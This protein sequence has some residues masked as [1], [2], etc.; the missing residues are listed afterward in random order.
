MNTKLIVRLKRKRKLREKIKSLGLYRLSVNRTS[1]HIYAQ[2]F[3]NDG[4]K[5]LVS[6]ST[7]DK[8]FSLKYGGNCEA[9]AVVGHLV[10]SRAKDLG[11][12][13]VVFDRSWFKYHGRI[14]AL[15]DAARSN[16]LIF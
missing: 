4:A 10:A 1:K 7:L 13:N 15:A 16:G 12:K 3:I 9:A 6:A 8:D 5:V 11:I 14:K 2:I